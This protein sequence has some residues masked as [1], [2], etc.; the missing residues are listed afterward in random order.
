LFLGPAI[1]DY[2]IVRAM[3][4]AVGAERAGIVAHAGD[5]A[6][7]P[8]AALVVNSDISS[9]RRPSILEPLEPTP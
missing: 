3:I 8:A 2:V 9:S 6:P 1:G 5:E 4:E 7:Q